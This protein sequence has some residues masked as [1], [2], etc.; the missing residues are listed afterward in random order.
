M[1]E[2]GSLN[3]KQLKLLRIPILK[4]N[5]YSNI[6]NDIVCFE[7]TIKNYLININIINNKLEN[8]IVKYL[9]SLNIKNKLSNDHISLFETTVNDDE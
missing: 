1:S 5:N 4:N 9:Q 8:Q 7:N 6:I 2:N 3:L